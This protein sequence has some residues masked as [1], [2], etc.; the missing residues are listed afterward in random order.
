[1]T[2]KPKLHV[3]SLSGGKDSTAM[4]L[5]MIEN[6]MQ[7]DIILFCDTGLEFPKMYEHLDKLEKHIGRKITRIKAKQ[8][9]EYLFSEH[10][11][12]RKRSEKFIEK[13]GEIKNGYGCL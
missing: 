4:L 12:K 5:K 11:I 1:M 10:K 3:V 2:D 6:N 9:F 13:Y 7:I 8:D